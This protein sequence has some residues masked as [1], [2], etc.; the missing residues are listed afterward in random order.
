MRQN[1]FIF[2]KKTTI[3]SKR[4][5]LRDY[6]TV[7]ERR[8][9]L[10][11]MLTISLKEIG[12]SLVDERIASQKN[13]ENMIGTIQVPL[14][15]AGPLSI[16]TDLS[17]EDLYLPLATT[18]GA[19]VA[20]INRGTKALTLS[21]GAYVTEKTIGITRAPV[22]VVENLQKANVFIQWVE[23]HTKEIK[24]IAEATGSHITL[25]DT[26]IWHNGKN[27]F[28]RFLFDT[29]DAMGMNMAT[30]ATTEIAAFITSQTHIPSSSI[31]SNLCADKKP[32]YLNFIEGRGR[33]V[34]ADATIGAEVLQS[35]LKTTSEQFFDTAQ[36]KLTSGSL[37]SGSIGANA[38]MANVLS[39]IFLATGQDIAHVAE[40]AV[41]ITEVEKSGKDIYISVFL[42]DLIVGTVG[43]GTMLPTQREA[44]NIL[45][46]Q[47]GN[48]GQNAK[49]LAQ[50][51]AASVLAGE[52][53]LLAALSSTD[54]AKAHE[55][56]ARGGKR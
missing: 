45:G 5:Y 43:G 24:K 8:L 42:P 38:H 12:G 20:S 10:E 52:V 31:S 11:K 40:C 27:V 54:L 21:G 18:E 1:L 28:V 14:G 3:Y 25:L 6:Q 9:A 13:C 41:G 19:L 32:N 51:I 48:H 29:Q 39:A 22:F 34:W 56:L 16:K 44:L 37:L 4:M 2:Q 26:K 46:V 23:N 15:I 50:I 30:I 55:K 36:R 33:Q 47:G 49:R 35:V 7:K 17:Q 53:S